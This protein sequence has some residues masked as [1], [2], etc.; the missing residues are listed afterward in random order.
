MNFN[1]ISP[2]IRIAMRSELQAPFRINTRIIFDYEIILIERGSWKLTVEDRDYLCSQSD[3][4]LIRPH[5]SHRIESVD[6]ISVSQPHIHFDM[7]YDLHS[8]NVYVSFKNIDSFSDLEKSMIR[9]DIFE[10]TCLTSPILKIIDFEAFKQLF[11]LIIDI[12]QKKEP[13]YELRYKQKMLELLYCVL[14]DNIPY[15]AME[16][17]QPFNK[18]ALIKEYIDSNYCSNITL[19]GLAL[20]FHYDRFYISKQFKKEYGISA[21]KYYNRIRVDASKKILLK[22]LSVTKTAEYLNFDSI[23]SFSRF[24]KNSVGFSPTEYIHIAK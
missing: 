14:Q 18:M 23:Y 1:F 13:M 17:K 2:Y 11:F 8:E 15:K 7:Q 12:F 5:Q 10:G 19:N 9:K 16:Q 6:N 22:T 24:F 3:V 4:I 21:I 20:Q